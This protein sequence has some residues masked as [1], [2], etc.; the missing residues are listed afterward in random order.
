MTIYTPTYLYIKTHN[1]TGLKYFGKTIFDPYTYKGSGKHWVRHLEK[2]GDD[3]STEIYGYYEDKDEL[4]N[5]ALTFSKEHDIVNSKEWANLIEENGLDGVVPGSTAKESTK[6]LMSEQRKGSIPWNKGKTYTIQK[7]YGKGKNNPMY[8]KKH[9]KS[10]LEKMKKAKENYIPWNKGITEE[11]I[12]CPHCD[13]KGSKSMMKRWHF[14]N[15]RNK[16]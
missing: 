12:K 7:E 1:L 9:K 6:K 13:M 14:D 16:V 4:V 10:S 3:V 2:H 8:G 15:C 11:K 5:T